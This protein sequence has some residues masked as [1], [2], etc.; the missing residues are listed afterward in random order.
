MVQDVVELSFEYFAENF[1]PPQTLTDGPW[2]PDEA[3]VDRFDVDLL[4]VR[5]VRVHVRLQAPAAF[6]GR[7][8]PLFVRSGTASSL[9]RSVPD[10]QA[11][12]DIALRNSD[13]RR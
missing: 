6:R 2:H 8:G 13:A 3:S 11:R 7:A 4:R 10:R 5:R 9:A 1:L 12:F